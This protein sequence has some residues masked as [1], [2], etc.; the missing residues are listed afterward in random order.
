MSFF[1]F[2]KEK[3]SYIAAY[4]FLTVVTGVFLWILDVKIIFLLLVFMLWTGLFGVL[5]I[6]EYLN[7]RN[8]YQ[9]LEQLEQDLDYKTILPA[10][11]EKANFAEG[12]LFMRELSIADKYM[13]DRIAAYERSA[14]E[15]KEY[16]ELWVHEIKN[17][18]TTIQL[19]LE[20]KK[21]PFARKLTEEVFNVE[22]LVEQAL[23][24][25]RGSSLEKDFLIK[26][27]TLHGLVSEA[28]KKNAKTL[29]GAGVSIQQENLEYTVYADNKWLLFMLGQI[30]S[31]AVKYKKEQF[32][33]CFFGERSRESVSLSVRD[34]GI[35]IKA[36]EIDRIF[37]KGFTGTNGRQVEKS[38]GLGLYLCRLLAKK[39]NIGLKAE[40]VEDVG[41]TITFI[42]PVNSMTEEVID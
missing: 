28:L 17:P 38:T 26:P 34:N 3:W 20:N 30:L 32:T 36:Q 40:S 24:Y 14:R 2:I 12:N 7:K 31:N 15:Y 10:L 29:I 18:I 5:F 6:C 41:T 37:D 8:F 22:N 21:E 16:V 13:N 19:M 9:N 27:V 33:L 23:F 4:I 35:G 42:F 1:D 11:M 25:A 39:M